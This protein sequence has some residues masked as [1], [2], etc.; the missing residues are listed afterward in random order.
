MR[1]LRLTL[2]A[3]ILSTAVFAQGG[4]LPNGSFE[5]G[6][7]T[8]TGWELSGRPGEWAEG[9]LTGDRC[10]AVTGD[11]STS[12]SWLTREVRFEPGQTAASICGNRGVTTYY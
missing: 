11:G 1:Q 5:E 7:D 2:V 8:A 12:N 3:L 6:A 4:L 10:V 9:G